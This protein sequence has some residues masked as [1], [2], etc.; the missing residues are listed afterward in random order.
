MKVECSP[1]NFES[2]V[3]RNSRLRE[4]TA[5]LVQ[6]V[7]EK[8]HHRFPE[9]SP[10]HLNLMGV[11]GV[12]LGAWL[13]E[14]RN[15]K[16][17]TL[18]SL[19]PLI[20]L[21]VSSLLDAFDGSLARLI[22]RED[23]RK[24]DF[25]K[26]QLFDAGSDRLQELTMALSRI[27]SANKRGDKIGETAAILAVVTNPLPSVARSLSESSGRVV[28]EAGKGPLGF[29][30]T[31]VGRAVVGIASTVFPEVSKMPLQTSLDALTGVAN[32]VT[33]IDRVHQGIKSDSFGDLAPEKRKEATARAKTLLVLTG[34]TF[35]ATLFTYRRL[36]QKEK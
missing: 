25:F 27:V 8:L 26:G 12:S 17:E 19:P 20:V 34:V 5:D 24:V 7:T 23:P 9:L 30:G 15:R 35:G 36:R 31:R 28:P 14:R 33:T 32:V 22:A 18:S 13:A 1:S 10:T 21:S 4:T 11:A 6:K 16:K 2:E 3:T 29:L